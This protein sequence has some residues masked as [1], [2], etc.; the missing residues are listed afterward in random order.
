MAD[1][2]D[3]GSSSTVDASSLKHLSEEEALKLYFAKGYSNAQLCSVLKHAHGI[4]LT[5]DQVK[6]RLVK[7]GLRR[8]GPG[9]QP[10]LQ[11]IEDAIQVRLYSMSCKFVN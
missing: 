9:T 6:K 1:S 10:P 8:R 11:V 4:T 7:L 2:H 3:C 5:L